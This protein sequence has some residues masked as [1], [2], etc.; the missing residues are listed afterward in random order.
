MLS[1]IHIFTNQLAGGKGILVFHRNDLIIDLGVQH[2]RYK[3]CADALDLMAA[4]H[5]LT[6]SPPK[7]SES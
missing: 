3:P 1:L 7:N 5:T 4:G 6:Y 2:I